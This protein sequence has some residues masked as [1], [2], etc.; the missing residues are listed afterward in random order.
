MS[1]SPSFVTFIFCE[2]AATVISLR[3]S[4]KKNTSLVSIANDEGGNGLELDDSAS[5]SKTISN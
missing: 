3:S 5:D 4:S 1:I 2:S